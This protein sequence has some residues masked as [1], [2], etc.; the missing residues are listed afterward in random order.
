MEETLTVNNLLEK[1]KKFR[2]NL[3]DYLKGALIAAVTTAI[4]L[5]LT[6]IQSKGNIDIKFI[7]ESGALAGISYLV[8]N[9]FE[10]E[11]GSFIENILTKFNITITKDGI[12]KIILDFLTKKIKPINK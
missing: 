7:L 6:A 4:A 9:F 10:G 1:S 12:S 11:N 5:V 3:L 8:K 2:L